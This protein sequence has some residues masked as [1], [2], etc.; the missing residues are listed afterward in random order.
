MVQMRE[1]HEGESIRVKE[2]NPIIPDP[3]R[4]PKYITG[5]VGMVRKLIG[6]VHCSPTM[7][8]VRLIIVAFST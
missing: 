1:F 7:R 8:S 3:R 5:K 2:K 6:Y 4:V